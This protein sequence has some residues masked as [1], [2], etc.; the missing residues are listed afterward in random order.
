VQFV[1]YHVVALKDLGEHCEE[2]EEHEAD[3]YGLYGVDDQGDAYAI[4][5]FQTRED[6]E[7]IKSGIMT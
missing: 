3:F 7:L 1:D 2:C 5:D 4:G 6:A